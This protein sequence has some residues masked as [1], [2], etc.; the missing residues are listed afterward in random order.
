MKFVKELLANELKEF[1]FQFAESLKSSNALL[2][3]I[4]K[5]VS[6]QKGKQLRPVLVLLSARLCDKITPDTYRAACLVEYLHAATLVH[7]DVIDD[8]FVRRGKYSVKA[9]WGSKLAVI[10]GD[11]MLSKGLLLAL[12]ND[13]YQILQI[14]SSAVKNMA[15]A[16]MLQFEKNVYRTMDEKSYYDIIRGK[17]A[18]LFASACSMG[19]WSASKNVALRDKLYN[20]GEHLGMAFQI[21]DDLTDFDNLALTGK[22]KWKDIKSKK[23]TLPY[24]YALKQASEKDKQKL[25]SLFNI[26]E[27]SD[28]DMQ[29]IVDI[30]IDLGGI[31]YASKIMINYSNLAIQELSNFPEGIERLA[32]EDLIQYT[33]HRNA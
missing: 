5:Y 22:P 2:D 30:I 9:L 21:K 24:L 19:A 29:D 25:K 28:K 4:V 20:L 27:A 31:D 18:S 32:F 33:T 10:L 12:H 3:K 26:K 6:A 23:A 13:D 15:E 17:T 8:S 16:E 14:L 1:D 11:Y 7:D